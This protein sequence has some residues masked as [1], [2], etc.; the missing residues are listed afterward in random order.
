LAGQYAPVVRS[1]D[2][3]LQEGADPGTVRAALDRL[4]PSLDEED[5]RGFEWYHLDR[6]ARLEGG[7]RVAGHR[8]PVDVVAVSPDRRLL[9]SCSIADVD[10]RVWDIRVWDIPGRE[11]QQ[12]WSSVGAPVASLAF[13]ADGQTLIS[14]SEAPSDKSSVMCIG[15][16]RDWRQRR[17]HS[18]FPASTAV[19]LP[20]SKT[21]VYGGKAHLSGKPPAV[22][23]EPVE[24]GIVVADVELMREGLEVNASWMVAEAK[25]LLAS[26]SEPFTAVACSPDGRTLAAAHGRMGLDR[27]PEVV[28][29][30]WSLPG[31]VERVPPLRV[32][33]PVRVL[34][35]SAD[36][37]GLVVGT[38]NGIVIH[39]DL[40]SGE[41]RQIGRF[42][43]R[44]FGLAVS[45]TG[46]AVAMV[47]DDEPVPENVGVVRVVE[48]PSGR[49]LWALHTRIRPRAVAFAGGGRSL[50]LGCADG[51][52]RFWDLDRVAGAASTRHSVAVNCVASSP[53][54]RVIAAALGDG[55]LLLEGAGGDRRL[56]TPP[57][58]RRL[59]ALAFSP[60]GRWLAGGDDGGSVTAWDPATGV[61]RSH[62]TVAGPVSAVAYTGDGRTLACAG[63]NGEVRLWDCDGGGLR[64]FLPSG[65]GRTGGLATS[66]G[67]L[68]TL[69]VADGS[70]V[71][72]WDLNGFSPAGEYRG[73]SPVGPMAFSPDGRTL[74]AGDVDGR[75]VLWEVGAAG[76]RSIH[77]GH[78]GAVRSLSFSP[79]GRTLA[80]GGDDSAVRLWQV[81]SGSGLTTLWG[82]VGVVR[83]VQFSTA[84]RTLVSGGE[85][86]LV[87]VWG[88]E[89]ARSGTPPGP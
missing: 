89:D 88:G 62:W 37:S 74:A 18:V 60:D 11:L 45:P 75:V 57:S 51:T 2:E 68:P 71:R 76:W 6:I 59:T 21:L 47:P 19:M 83:G 82:H 24:R 32:P 22:E 53:D 87:H 3:L 26:E 36:G 35:F 46:P 70:V 69:A 41:Y 27:H 9:A 48:V 78:A 20:D 12:S 31:G 29:R 16:G 65:A 80:S 4:R 72:L 17:S 85:D 52:V 67:G 63:G 7:D 66:S 56:V 43:G 79:D 14:E 8:G 81:A 10:F 54:G 42:S 5:L 28:V 86:G 73:P 34:G 33:A 44:R 25:R 61:M 1:V 40:K 15:V 64:W 58:G 38:E 13:S 50:A 55:T 23:K 84:G 49:L 39:W 77:R 30:L